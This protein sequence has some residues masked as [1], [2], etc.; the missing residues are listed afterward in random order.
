MKPVTERPAWFHPLQFTA[1]WL[2]LHSPNK[3]GEDPELLIQRE[4]DFLPAGAR[5]AASFKTSRVQT[6]TNY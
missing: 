2:P 5:D 6:Q 1:S 3:A 4:C